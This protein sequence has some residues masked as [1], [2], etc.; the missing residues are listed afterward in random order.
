MQQQNEAL[1]DI[2]RQLR[3]LREEW[4]DFRKQA[5][6]P[7]KHE[8]R[9]DL[10]K[11]EYLHGNLHI[12]VKP[13]DGGTDP[14][15][16]ALGSAP[17]GTPQRGPE[18]EEPHAG[19]RRKIAEFM[20]DEAAEILRRIESEQARPLDDARRRWILGDVEKQIGERI[21][22]YVRQHGD[23]EMPDRDMEREIVEKVKRDI[24][25]TFE[26]YIQH[27]GNG[28]TGSP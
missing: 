19:I 22:H 4:L 28:G 25:R 7:V 20:R 23:A 5:G 1:R 21:R 26:T 17:D 6:Q 13:A 8:Y 9:F 12:G 15:Q 18:Q 11:V 14:M 24:I 16:L 2:E 27:L 10:L 3:L